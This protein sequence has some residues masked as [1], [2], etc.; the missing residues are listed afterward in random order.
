MTQSYNLSSWAKVSKNEFVKGG[1]FSKKIP[2]IFSGDLKC[3][4]SMIF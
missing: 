1:T 3:A 4:H 2:S